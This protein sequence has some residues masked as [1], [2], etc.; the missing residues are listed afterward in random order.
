MKNFKTNNIKKN[1]PKKGITLIALV[2]TIVILLLLAAIVLH[3]SLGDNGIIL[4]TKEANTKNTYSELIDNSKAEVTALA[5]DKTID[6]SLNFDI[7]E[8]YKRPFFVNNYEIVN[9]NI[10]KKD[11]TT[12][13]ISKND[14]ETILKPVFED[15]ENGGNPVVTPPSTTPITPPVTPPRTRNRNS[16]TSSF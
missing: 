8:I 14:Y 15:T 10:V 12:P 3:F 1:K 2:I 7:K 11:T 9:D 16:Y 5:L 6:D 13:I 4:K